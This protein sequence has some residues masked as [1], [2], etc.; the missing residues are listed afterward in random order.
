MRTANDRKA[1]EA[2]K[3]KELIELRSSLDMTQAELAEALDVDVIT[4]SRWERGVQRIPE[5]VRLAI[6]TL[7]RRRRK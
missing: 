2:M 1:R 6:E 7:R 3:P 5:M 4:V